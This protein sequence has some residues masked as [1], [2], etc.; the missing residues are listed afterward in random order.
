MVESL[1][2]QLL[3]AATYN[4]RLLRKPAKHLP[5]LILGICHDSIHAGGLALAGQQPEVAGRA[6]SCA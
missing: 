6:H 3:M 4:Y 2:N 5:A 1:L